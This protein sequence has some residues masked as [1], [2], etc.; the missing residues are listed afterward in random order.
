MGLLPAI[1]SGGCLVGMEKI[2]R[3]THLGI[4]GKKVASRVGS[5]VFRACTQIHTGIHELLAQHRVRFR[6]VLKQP[7]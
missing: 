5:W 2:N 6:T 1:N 7:P 4:G 3:I